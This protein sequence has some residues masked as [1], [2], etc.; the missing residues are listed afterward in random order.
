MKRLAHPASPLAIPS[1]EEGERAVRE[2]ERLYRRQLAAWASDVL[3]LRGVGLTRAT[4]TGPMRA[5]D[6]WT[7]AA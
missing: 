1:R 3:R 7:T 5:E 2:A 4:W 6:P